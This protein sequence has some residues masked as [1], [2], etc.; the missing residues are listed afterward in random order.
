M[1]NDKKRAEGAPEN[2]ESRIPE[3]G[4][5]LEIEGIW[6]VSPRGAR[7]SAGLAKP[8]EIA[9]KPAEIQ[10]QQGE[11]RQ[12]IRYPPVADDF[13]VFGGP[14]L[15]LFGQIGRVLTRS[16][17]VVLYLANYLSKTESVFEFHIFLNFLILKF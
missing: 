8:A 10:A 13:E 6:R 16:E 4:Q 11:T 15:S 5:I 17:D 9:A 1:Q 3:F 2:F 12:I 7:I 14:D